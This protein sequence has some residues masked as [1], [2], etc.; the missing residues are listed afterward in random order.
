MVAEW[1]GVPVGF[2][3]VL[4]AEVKGCSCRVIDLI[5]VSNSHQG[6]GGGRELVDYFRQLYAGKCDLLRVGTQVANIPSARLYER[7]GFRL[8]ESAYV[9]HAHVKDGKLLR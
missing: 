3:A 9:L 5:G 6:R 1:D 7:C 2:L 8:A 4:A